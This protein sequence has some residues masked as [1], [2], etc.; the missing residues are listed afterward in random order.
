MAHHTAT[1]QVTDKENIYENALEQEHTG[2]QDY[3]QAMQEIWG[4]G[5][6]ATGLKKEAA[7]D[8]LF[9]KAAQRIFTETSYRSIIRNLIHMSAL[10]S[11]K[12]AQLKEIHE[13]PAAT[14]APAMPPARPAL[15]EKNAERSLEESASF[16]ATARK[17][18]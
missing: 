7:Q 18:S 13:K 11:T 3:N 10:N 8:E 14:A 12:A 5:G 15:R 4:G 16:D 9:E 2:M 1:A 6:E 17:V